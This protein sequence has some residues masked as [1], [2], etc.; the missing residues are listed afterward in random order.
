LAI[1]NY[2]FRVSHELFTV[3]IK[4]PDKKLLQAKVEEFAQMFELKEG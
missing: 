1:I 4:L 2:Q 3:T